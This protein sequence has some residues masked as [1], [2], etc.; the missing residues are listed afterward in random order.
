MTGL[1][2]LIKVLLLVAL[3]L[4]VPVLVVW[5]LFQLLRLVTY[6]LGLLGRGLRG[7]TRRLVGFVHASVLDALRGAG[8][9]LAAALLL[10]LVALNF[11][12]LRWRSGVHYGRAL[13]DELGLFALS[14][15]R[16][17]LGNPIRLLGL[18]PLT[19]GLERRIPDLMARAPRGGRGA[20]GADFEGYRVVGTLPP[21]GSGARLYLARPRPEKLAALRLAGKEDPDQ[22]VIKS[23]ALETG[24]TL[25][26]IVRES[27]ALEAASRLGLV[28]EHHLAERSFHYVMPYVPGRDLDEVTS[29][30]HAAAPP[31]GLGTR[32]LRLVLSYGADLLRALERFHEGGLW[33]KDIKPGN[34][35][36][37]QGRVHVVDLG[38]VTPLASAL[39]L[40]TH[41]TEYYRDPEMVRLAMQGVKVH[42]VDGV[43][44]DIYSAGAVLYSMIEGSFPA[45]GSLSR[46]TRRCPEAL[47]WIVRRAMADL[48][49]R[50]GSAREMLA[51]VSALL[52]AHD[53]F[54]LKPAHLPSVRAGSAA[55]LSDS[56]PTPRP[57]P[58]RPEPAFPG[59]RDDL[60]RDPLGAPRQRRVG[61]AVLLAGAAGTL[62]YTGLAGVLGEA[63]TVDVLRA[64]MDA[65]AGRNPLASA[66]V[67][68]PSAE[69]N[70]PW[71]RA[72]FAADRERFERYRARWEEHLGDGLPAA[73]SGALLVLEDLP[74]GI[75]PYLVEALDQVLVA[76]GHRVLAGRV[77]DLD[78]ERSIRLVA[79]ARFAAGLGGPADPNSVRGLQVFLDRHDELTGI[80]WLAPGSQ[81][82]ALAYR[83]LRPS[84][85]AQEEPGQ[86]PLAEA[87]SAR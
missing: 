66:S 30:L 5:G 54:G 61:R 25:P 85:G 68:A 80:L 7:G 20:A 55:P 59:A 62:L 64:R 52:A 23:F 36:V 13:E 33:H 75:D 3:A 18:S 45:H 67:P 11:L 71:V 21:G 40:T 60:G 48:R 10:P 16:L 73:G 49:T 77:S 6:I 9:L 35:I 79:G 81:P 8:A 19:D 28:L 34:L 15:Y 12:V 41:G 42:E 56:S 26:Q 72:S 1:L 39:T 51:D 58:G 86:F 4:V 50:Y 78:D 38:L 37:S 31:D 87:L 2:A 69:E 43:K 74:P 27:R 53:P 29:R 65:F 70:G 63:P 44:F 84:G 17:A 14:V 57:A 22:V 32:D 46:I 83:L 76:R 82:E 47:Q 24:S